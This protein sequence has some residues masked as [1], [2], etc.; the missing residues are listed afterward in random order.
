MM[1]YPIVHVEF[2]AADPEETSKFYQDAFG[3]KLEAY[4]E[5]NY[6]GFE[7]EPGPGGGFNPIDGETIKP[8][9]VIVYIQTPD[10]EASLAKIESLGG[11][12]LHPKTEIPNIG[13]YAFFGDPAGNRVALFTSKGE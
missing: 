5:M 9:D 2:S 6:I 3:W 8:G 12:T 7:A 11:T 1:A 10:I 13:W 4:P